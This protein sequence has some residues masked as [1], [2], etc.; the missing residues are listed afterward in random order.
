MG[1]LKQAVTRLKMLL[2]RIPLLLK[3][4][5]LHGI[6]MSPMSG[7]QDLRTELL[8]VLIRS[9]VTGE[10]TILKTQKGSMRDPGIR[11]PMWISKVTLPQ[12][13]F[14]VRDAV[15]R[16]IEELGNGQETFHTPAVAAV[17]AEWTGYRSGVDK[18]A[19]QPDISEEE[20]YHRLRKEI[21]SDITILY[22]HGGAY[23]LM[24]PC[25]HRVPVA[26]VSRQTGAPVFSVR[27]RLAPQN[28]FP[29][30]L[31]DA[32]TAYLSLI[33]PPEG[34]LHKPVPANKIVIAGDSA[35]GNLSFVLLQTLLTL[36]RVSRSVRFHGKDVDIELPGGVGGIS[37]WC[38]V[39]L[40]MPSIVK[41]RQFD[42]MDIRPGRVDEPD[43]SIPFQS[44]PFPSD[45]A[46]PVSPPRVDLF[47]NANAMSHPLVSPIAANP[48]LW[49][50]SPPVFISVGEECLTDEGLIL[51][52]RMHQAGV[53]VAAQMFEGMPHCH[54]II[55]ISTPTG[56]K[57]WDGLCGFFRDV[58]MSRVTRSGH[59][60]H[61]AFKLRSERDI[62]LE[63]ACDVGDDEVEER[64]RKH[65]GW[66]LETENKMQREWRERSRL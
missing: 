4:L 49:K 42:Y 39:T 40:S 54:G 55:M 61:H 2:I 53:P 20:K 8:T 63:K 12:P 36:R 9:F 28:P 34:S 47:C 44:H 60:R 41:N 48:E 6:H 19:P 24:D 35:G 15:L 57:F 45:A 66:R 52:R 5:V 1:G 18:K 59:L 43:F 13:E 62:P 11:G 50:D 26:H 23:F 65:T 25:T 46:W 17:E 29:A 51:A 14:D 10:D 58:D 7:K 27:Y 22:F 3:T 37:P 16:A 38:D 21:T 31:V 56:K 32:L 30:A 33:H 64:L